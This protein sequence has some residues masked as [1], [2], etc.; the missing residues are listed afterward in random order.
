MAIW[1]LIA[2]SYILIVI[3]PH[4]P[5]SLIRIRIPHAHI[6]SPYSRSHPIS[7][8]VTT[9][10]GRVDKVTMET[11]VETRGIRKSSLLGYCE[12]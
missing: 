5:L 1:S 10:G 11:E 3:P 8:P 2:M 4:H 9:L 7:F 6:Y 12:Y